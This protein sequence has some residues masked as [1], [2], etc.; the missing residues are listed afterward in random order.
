MSNILMFISA[1]DCGLYA[2]VGSEVLAAVVMKC[3]I[4]SDISPCNPLKINRLIGGNVVSIFSGDFYLLLASL[5]IIWF[6]G[7]EE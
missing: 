1:F 7:A 3:S 5:L 4:L 2:Y 6:F